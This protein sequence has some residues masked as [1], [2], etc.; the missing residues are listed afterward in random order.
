LQECSHAET[1]TSPQP[2]ARIS[3]C[4]STGVQTLPLAEPAEV[5]DLRSQ[6]AELQVELHRA[7]EAL[8][9][10]VTKDQVMGQQ[11]AAAIA[12]AET[13]AREQVAAA[14]KEADDSVT[15]AR[16]CL[17]LLRICHTHTHTHTHIPAELCCHVHSHL[18]LHWI[19]GNVAYHCVCTVQ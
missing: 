17:S 5:I 14:R 2:R 19:D 7:V 6:V 15:A 3:P 11:A 1:Q 4:E 10:R 9:Q 8:E 13:Y 16:C 12:A 18:F